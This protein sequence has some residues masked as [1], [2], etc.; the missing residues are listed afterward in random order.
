MTSHPIFRPVR[1]EDKSRIL[2]FTRNTWGADDSDYIADVFDEWL[3]D[4]RGEFTAAVLDDQVVAIAK[5]TDLGDD[6]WWFEGL[7][8]DVPYRRRG[9]GEALNRYQVDLARKSGGKIIRYMTGG[10]NVGSQ[11]I[12][13]KA[14]FEHT[15]T[16]SA[17]LAAASDRFSSP[18]RLTLDDLP[19]LK[20]WLDS[21]LMRYQRGSYRD[22][23]T[24][25]TLTEAEMRQTIDSQRA[26]GVKD[27]AGRVRAWAVLRPSDYD[28]DSEDGTPHRLR[29][30]HL[31]GEPEALIELAQQMRTL[32]AKLHRP[33]VSAGISDYAPLIEAMAKASYTINPD[34][35]GLWIMELAL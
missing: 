2:D 22:A 33:E 18:T 12:G 15:L 16:F 34:H 25:K 32:A 6:E 28:E 17:H 29:V 8:V 3:I 24:V 26:Y 23:W 21:P 9:L 13:V 35:F 30:D 14:G 31:D 19:A 27:T 11:A 7:R 20:V 10:E 1:S 4:P 5:L